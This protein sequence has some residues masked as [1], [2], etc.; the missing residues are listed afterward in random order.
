VPALGT[1][2]IASRRA[3]RLR[4]ACFVVGVPICRRSGGNPQPSTWTSLA[5]RPSGVNNPGGFQRLEVS[6]LVIDLRG[7]DPCR[8]DRAALIRFDSLNHK[9]DQETPPMGVFHARWFDGTVV[10]D[11]HEPAVRPG[12]LTLVLDA[13]VISGHSSVKVKSMTRNAVEPPCRVGY[14]VTGIH[15]TASTTT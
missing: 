8:T 6:L 2:E 11:A 4:Q 14:C 1:T 5:R 7:D 12:C 9:R 15:W 3:G 13:L 10:N